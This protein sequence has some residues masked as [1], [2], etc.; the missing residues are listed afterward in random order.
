M[1]SDDVT[2]SKN[3]SKLLDALRD[4]YGDDE[5]ILEELESPNCDYTFYK[6]VE[7]KPIAVTEA[8]RTILKLNMG[9]K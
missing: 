6:A 5:D 1:V 4:F 8:T 3:I 2:V 9:E 7:V